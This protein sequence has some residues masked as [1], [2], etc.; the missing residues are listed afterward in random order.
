MDIGLLITAIILFVITVGHT[1]MFLETSGKANKIIVICSMM[2]FVI[3]IMK[4]RLDIIKHKR[5]PSFN[6][7]NEEF[8]V[9]QLNNKEII[10]PNNNAIRLAKQLL[11]HPMCYLYI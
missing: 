7:I 2:L 9:A 10:N 11:T 4:H 8:N 1:N 6:A 5:Q 3:I